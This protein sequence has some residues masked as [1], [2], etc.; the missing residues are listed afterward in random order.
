MDEKIFDY[1]D[2]IPATISNELLRYVQSIME[3][4]GV[5]YRAFSRKKTKQSVEHKF[6]VK[7]YDGAYKMQDLFGVRITL[8]FKDDVSVCK[9]IIEE[10]GSFQVVDISEDKPD[11]ESFKPVR[12]NY[13]CKLP[14]DIKDYISS[15]FW[16]NSQIDDT[17]E[18]QIRTVLSEGW[19]EIEHD[20]RYKC[21]EDWI[22]EKEMNRS[23]NG[24][25][26]T[27]ETCD[28]SIISMFDQLAYKKYKSCKWSAMFRNKLRLRTADNDISVELL[29]IMDADHAFAKELLKVSRLDLILILSNDLISTVPKTM[30][31]II[32]VSNFFFIHNKL[33]DEKT[34]SLLQ[35]RCIMAQEQVQRVT[36]KD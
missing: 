25:F 28:W 19:H 17:F 7:K 12:L 30:D 26:A 3:R 27:L 9:S 11:P 10:S 32:Y 14:K 36:N 2:S 13:V 31:N 33:V 4:S 1:I 29:E 22:E 34:P 16:Y 24:I 35:K 20:L 18:I 21:K 8:Y 5:F 15:D 6:N 23:L